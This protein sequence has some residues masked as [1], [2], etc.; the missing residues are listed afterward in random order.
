MLFVREEADF[1]LSIPLAV[2]KILKGASIFHALENRPN[3]FKIDPYKKGRREQDVIFIRRK[4]K[5]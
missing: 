4:C 2:N 3:F 5:N 1:G